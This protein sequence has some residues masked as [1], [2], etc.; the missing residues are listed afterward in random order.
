MSDCEEDE[1]V[2]ILRI[3]DIETNETICLI[4]RWEDGTKQALW[5]SDHCSDS[6]CMNWCFAKLA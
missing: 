5:I 4:Y 3:V 2:A 1:A 6:D